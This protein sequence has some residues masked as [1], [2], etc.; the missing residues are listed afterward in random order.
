MEKHNS[1]GTKMTYSDDMHYTL[2]N[3]FHWCHSCGNYRVDLQ[4][5]SICE[6]CRNSDSRKK[7]QAL[8]NTKQTHLACDEKFKKVTALRR[9]NNI[10]V[11]SIKRLRMIGYQHPEQLELVDIKLEIALIKNLEI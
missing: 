10:S 6:N 5:N 1:M 9:A 8:E 4:V 2:A 11:D 3:E 7:Q